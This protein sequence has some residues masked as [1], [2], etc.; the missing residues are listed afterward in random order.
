MNGTDADDQLTEDQVL[1]LIDFWCVDLD[2]QPFAHED[3]W[4]RPATEWTP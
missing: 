2:A 1:F 4:R 3:F